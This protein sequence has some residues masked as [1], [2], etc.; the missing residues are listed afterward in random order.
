MKRKMQSKQ[1][2]EISFQVSCPLIQTGFHK[3]N[4]LNCLLKLNGIIL[5]VKINNLDF[6]NNF[7]C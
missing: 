5:L 1:K 6:T 2:K 3:K 7:N 4:Y